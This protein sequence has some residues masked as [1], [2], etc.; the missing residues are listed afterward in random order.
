MNGGLTCL[1]RMGLV[2]VVSSSIA[3][4]TRSTHTPVRPAEVPTLAG[5]WTGYFVGT[6]GAGEP[7]DMTIERDGRYA[8]VFPSGTTMEGQIS[9]ADG[10]LVLTND[11][12][13]GPAVDLAEATATLSLHQ[14]GERQH[15]VGF[16]ENDAGPFSFSFGR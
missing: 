16:G 8:I 15:L 6:S 12:L 3:C 14:K 4:A 2:L 9:V 1:L 13:S 5:F 7:A 10:R 11:Y